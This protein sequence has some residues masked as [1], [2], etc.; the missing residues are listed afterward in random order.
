V[1]YLGVN[2]MNQSNRPVSP[3]FA[4]KMAVRHWLADNSK[5]CILWS[6]AVYH[7]PDHDYEPTGEYRRVWEETTVSA[8]VR[9]WLNL[10]I[11]HLKADDCDVD[12]FKALFGYS[13]AEIPYPQRR[14][15]FDSLPDGWEET[16]MLADPQELTLAEI[17]GIWCD[18]GEG[19][20]FKAILTR[21]DAVRYKS[22]E[23]AKK[24]NDRASHF[25]AK[26]KVDFASIPFFNAVSREIRQAKR[27]RS[28]YFGG[29][30]SAER[31]AT[32]RACGSSSYW[33]D[34]D[35]MSSRLSQP[36]HELQELL[37]FCKLKLPCQY[38]LW[39]ESRLKK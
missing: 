16:Y 22:N 28:D 11:S 31:Y 13:W 21:K 8:L 35:Y 7:G 27:K 29:E 2:S 18:A 3:R 10:V 15:K 1:T 9:K 39:R 37:R 14:E 19:L 5:V 20:D 30:Q 4:V 6:G 34:N 17:V 38:A 23:W 32:Y 25:C 12:T 36:I 24:M 26:H 33:E